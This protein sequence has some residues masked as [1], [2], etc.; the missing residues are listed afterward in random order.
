MGENLNVSKCERFSGERPQTPSRREGLCPDW[1]DQQFCPCQSEGPHVATTQ[2][3]PTPAAYSP[4]RPRFASSA[5]PFLGEPV[6]NLAPTT[7]APSREGDSQSFDISSDF[8]LCAVIFCRKFSSRD[9]TFSRVTCRK[10][11]SCAVSFL[12]VF[13]AIRFWGQTFL[14]SF[15]DRR[16]AQT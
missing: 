9:V 3:P 16:S 11:S 7:F 15:D 2:S 12:A 6:Q 8:L 14:S 5:Q 1:A 4:P 13:H 10:F